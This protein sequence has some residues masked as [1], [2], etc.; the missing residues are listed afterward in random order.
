MVCARVVRLGARCGQAGAALYIDNGAHLT[1]I[2]NS[3]FNSSDPFSILQLASPVRWYCELGYWMPPTGNFFGAVEGCLKPCPRG[4]YGESHHL[5]AAT[6]SDGCQLCPPGHFCGVEATSLP[7][8]CPAGT[9]MPATG[10]ASRESC[11]P[12]RTGDQTARPHKRH[13]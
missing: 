10:A 13:A 6:G 5:T 3:T 11:V 12:V 9:R 4:Y 1:N 8:P 7:S 2:T